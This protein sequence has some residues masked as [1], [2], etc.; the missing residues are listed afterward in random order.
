MTYNSRQLTIKTLT[1]LLLVIGYLSLVIS[2][3]HAQTKLES[4]LEGVK[5]QVENLVTAKDEK[6]GGELGLRIETFKK[7]IEFSVSE[8]KDL[9]IKLLALDNLSEEE[10][11]WREAT[12]KKLNGALDYY[13]KEKLAVEDET[14]IDLDKIKELATNFKN[15]RDTT[16]LPVAERVNEFLLIHQEERAIQIAERRWTRIDEDIAKLEKAKIKGVG[17]LRNLLTD[18]GKLLEESKELN[19]RAEEAFRESYILLATLPA[20]ST[21]TSAGS[22][23]IPEILT[24]NTTSSTSTATSPA[25]DNVSNGTSTNEGVLEE[26]LEPNLASIKG[27][28]EDSLGKIKDAYRVF[29]EMSNL[30]RELLS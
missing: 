8:A 26:A 23:T 20:T 15:W 11:A 1:I 18:A 12:V 9:K 19:V 25:R 7:V 27:L 13:E 3:A 29:I 30:V 6:S 21:A 22:S 4:T 10:I 28:V 16:Y 5:G 17:E 2:P 14:E 24:E